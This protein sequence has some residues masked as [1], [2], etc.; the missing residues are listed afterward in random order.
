MLSG[1]PVKRALP[2]KRCLAC[3]S[4]EIDQVL[5][6]GSQHLSRFMA[7]GVAL[8]TPVFPLDLLVCEQCGLA[9][10]GVAVPKDLLYGED[11][12]YRSGI[13]ETIRGD[14]AEIVEQAQRVRP[15]SIN[16]IVLDIGCNDGTLLDFYP[17]HVQ[18]VGFDL[19]GKLEPEATAKGIRFINEAFN[20]NAFRKQLGGDGKAAIIT[21]IS[22]FYDLEDPNEFLRDILEILKDDGIL[23]VQQNYLV[24]MI[25]NNAFDNICH[26]HLEYYSLSTM[27]ALLARHDLTI[28][29]AS[30]N[31]ING[32]SIRTLICRKGS[33]PISPR[34]TTLATSEPNLLTKEY[35]QAFF[36]RCEQIKARV[37]GF[38][39]GEVLA[40]K[41]VYALGAS[42][43]GNTLLQYFG[44]GPS[45]I[46]AAMER[47]PEKFGKVIASVGIPI[48]SEDEGRRQSPDYFLV[49]PWHFKEQIVQR[50]A[51]YLAGGGKLLFPLPHPVVVSREGEMALPESS[52]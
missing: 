39:E 9:Q 21:A 49:L 48:V 23:V 36:D 13:S 41:R 6:L 50:E 28:F 14:L 18:R 2:T 35:Y 12:G 17:R 30:L 5:S 25:E 19:L 20:A 44:L 52:D 33:R 16:E 24:T 34:A 47:N 29:D 42:T 22:M 46:G 7:P 8:D 27:Q 10:L 51:A 15:L 3:H 31:D 4:G 32:G 11:Y 43:R 1:G 38:I 26:E 37:R 45:L 40:G